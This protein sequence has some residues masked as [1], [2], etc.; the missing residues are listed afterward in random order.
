MICGDAR[1]EGMPVGVIANQRGLIKGRAGERPRFGGIIYAE[2]A[3][4]S[5]L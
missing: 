1:I 5:L 3:L 2:S 4:L